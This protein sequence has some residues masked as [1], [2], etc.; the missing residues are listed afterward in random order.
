MTADRHSTATPGAD[1]SSRKVAITRSQRTGKALMSRRLKREAHASRRRPPSRQQGADAKQGNDRRASHGG[2]NIACHMPPRQSS[3]LQKAVREK[4]VPA[5]RIEL[6][7]SVYKTAALPLCYAGDGFPNNPWQKGRATLGVA[8]ASVSRPAFRS[9]ISALT[10]D[11]LAH[12]VERQHGGIGDVVALES[13]PGMSTRASTSQSS[14]VR[15]AGPCLGSKHETHRRGERRLVERRRPSESRPTSWKPAAFIS[16]RL[17]PRLRTV[18]TG[19]MS[20][21]PEADLASTRIRR[22]NGG[23]GEHGIDGKGRCRAQNGADVMRIGDMIERQH[24]LGAL[25]L[26]RG[27]R[28]Q[29]LD[30]EGAALMDSFRSEQLVE[31]IGRRPLR[32]QAASTP[33]GKRSARRACALRVASR[34]RQTRRGFFSADSTVCRP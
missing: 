10:G 24:Q 1:S 26:Q 7:P 14:R 19:T 18:V 31:R 29:R 34:R 17:S 6:R 2:A 32:R 28:L 13:R 9:T 11:R 25:Q 16:S 23:G 4:M 15:C 33:S 20:S 12:H 30:L 8:R 22:P 5:E 21:A 3:A 27:H